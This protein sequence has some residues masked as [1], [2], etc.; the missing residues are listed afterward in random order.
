MHVTR[1][2]D[3]SLRVLMYLATREGSTTIQEIADN[4]SISKNHLMKVVQ[5]LN[6]KGYVKATR[7]KNGG[8]TLGVEAESINLGQLVR[9]ME[10]GSPLV[11]CFGENGTC[12]ITP[13]CHLK[14]VFAEAL[15]S[16]FSTLDNYSLADLVPKNK[17]KELQKLLNIG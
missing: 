3:Y 17:R 16:F 12:V 4:Y 5:A 7:G 2:T 13:A 8:V 15:E 11:E 9:E 6:N 1:Y 10:Q 14:T